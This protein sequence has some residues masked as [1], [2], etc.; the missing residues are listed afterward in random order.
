MLPSTPCQPLPW[1]FTS[2]MPGQ[3]SVH[4]SDH[5]DCECLAPMDFPHALSLALVGVHF[6]DTQS[7][8]HSRCAAQGVGPERGSAPEAEVHRPFNCSQL[9]LPLFIPAPPLPLPPVL[10]RSRMPTMPRAKTAEQRDRPG[11]E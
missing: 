6:Q 4:L 8:T 2:L 5:R 1:L 3:L 11:A 9:S 10:V 7:V